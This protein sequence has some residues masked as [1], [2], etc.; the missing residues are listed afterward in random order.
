MDTRETTLT[1]TEL[2]DVPTC[3][4]EDAGM[5][6]GVAELAGLRVCT[7][8]AAGVLTMNRGLML[9]LPDRSAYQLT[10]VRSA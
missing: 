1:E 7:Y 8:E 2:E 6:D 9:E 3:A 4:L 10:I 5:A